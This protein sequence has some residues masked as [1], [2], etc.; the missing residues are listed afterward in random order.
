M[1]GPYDQESAQEIVLGF[2]GY[3]GSLRNFAFTCPS[4]HGGSGSVGSDGPISSLIAVC[5]SCDVMSMKPALIR[6]ALRISAEPRCTLM[7]R[8]SLGLRSVTSIKMVMSRS[9]KGAM[10]SSSTWAARLC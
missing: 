9:I 1:G 2:K 8:P 10:T 6:E 7:N 3:R 4:S 5:I